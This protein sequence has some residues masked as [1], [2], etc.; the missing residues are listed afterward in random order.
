MLPQQSKGGRPT[1][2]SRVLPAAAVALG[3][4][5][6]TFAVTTNFGLVRSSGLLLAPPSKPSPS[7]SPIILDSSSSEDLQNEAAPIAKKV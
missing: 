4:S 6:L 2:A 5:R 3:Q 1:K 7:P